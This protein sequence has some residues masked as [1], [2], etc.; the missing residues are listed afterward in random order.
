MVCLCLWQ[1]HNLLITNSGVV[2]LADFG[3]AHLQGAEEGG[4]RGSSYKK[5]QTLDIGSP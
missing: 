2:K 5:N 3:I 4:S 1:S